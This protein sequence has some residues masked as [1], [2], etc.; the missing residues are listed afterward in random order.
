MI[1]RNTRCHKLIPSG[2][3]RKKKFNKIVKTV[4]GKRVQDAKV[5]VKKR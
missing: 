3:K 2:Y 5:V 4:K 1:P